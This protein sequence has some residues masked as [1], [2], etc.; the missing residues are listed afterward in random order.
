VLVGVEFSERHR[1]GHQRPEL[2]AQFLRE[3]LVT[4]DSLELAPP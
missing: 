3:A 4:L 1:S 2:R